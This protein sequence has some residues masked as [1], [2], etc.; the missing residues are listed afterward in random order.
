MS[1]WRANDWAIFGETASGSALWANVE[2]RDNRVVFFS[3]NFRKATH[4]LRYLL[5]R[6]ERY[7]RKI[8]ATGNS[9]GGLSLGN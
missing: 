1:E 9:T 4:V 6:N 7:F 2:L 8:S 3:S 5:L